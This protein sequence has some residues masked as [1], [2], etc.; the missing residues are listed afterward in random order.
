[1][2]GNQREKSSIQSQND[3]KNAHPH[4]KSYNENAQLVSSSDDDEKETDS[5]TIGGFS[6]HS[7]SSSSGTNNNK[8]NKRPYVDK[9]RSCKQARI[10]QQK[11]QQQQQKPWHYQPRQTRDLKACF[12]ILK[13]IGEGTFGSVFLTLDR[14]EAHPAQKQ[15]TIKRVK[16]RDDKSVPVYGF[17]YTALREIKLLESIEHRNVIK[18]HEVVTQAGK[19]ANARLIVSCNILYIG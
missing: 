19:I 13:H 8:N 11:L 4:D 7:S 1:M 5:S 17:P 2:N 3:E 6:S 14:E 18:M 15:K 10:I 9:S 16:T 12:R